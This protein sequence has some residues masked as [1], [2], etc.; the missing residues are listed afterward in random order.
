MQYIYSNFVKETDVLE[1]N[2]FKFR[3]QH[4]KMIEN[5]IFWLKT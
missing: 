2:G 5:Y 4:I 3:I 1:G